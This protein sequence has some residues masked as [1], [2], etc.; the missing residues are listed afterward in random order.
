MLVL[1][2]VLILVLSPPFTG[3][4]HIHEAAVPPHSTPLITL[5]DPPPSIDPLI[6]PGL[7]AHWVPIHLPP[8]PGGPLCGIELDKRTQPPSAPLPYLITGEHGM[9]K[10]FYVEVVFWTQASAK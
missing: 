2:L 10:A 1:V 5:I 3:V 4:K 8:T 7:D 6:G 9:D